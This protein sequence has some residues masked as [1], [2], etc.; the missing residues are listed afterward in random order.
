[1]Q[2]R[3]I[4][5]QCRMGQTAGANDLSQKTGW[6]SWMRAKVNLEM[7]SHTLIVEPHGSVYVV[8]IGHNIHWS[9]CM[10]YA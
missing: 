8:P 1:M 4:G 6:F 2:L 3:S 7:A 5:D 10:L 9:S